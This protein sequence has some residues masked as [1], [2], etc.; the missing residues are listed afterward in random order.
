M[1]YEP[2]CSGD[3]ETMYKLQNKSVISVIKSFGNFDC[4]AFKNQTATFKNQLI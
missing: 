3:T 1:F 4:L 2:V